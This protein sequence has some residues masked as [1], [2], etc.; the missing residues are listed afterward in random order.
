MLPTFI[1]VLDEII[2][3]VKKI[4][5]GVSMVAETFA[6]VDEF[7]QATR[8]KYRDG[9]YATRVRFRNRPTIGPGGDEVVETFY[10][11]SPLKKP[12]DPDYSELDFEYLPNGGWGLA[13]PTLWVTSWENHMAAVFSRKAQG[14]I[15]PLRVIHSAPKNAPLATMG[16]LGAVA[17]DPKRQEILAP[18]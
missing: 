4:G 3:F 10:T 9:T 7:R 2:R 13:A 18:N 14:N 15:A 12:L 5:R 6:E 8:R 1:Y 11:I 16:R 17:F